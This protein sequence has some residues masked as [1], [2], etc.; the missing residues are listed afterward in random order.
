ML[1]SCWS[2]SPSSEKS[3]EVSA[4]VELNQLSYFDWFVHIVID[5]WFPVNLQLYYRDALTT[6]KCLTGRAP[7]YLTAK[8]TKRSNISKRV[9]R[10]SQKLNIP[11]FRTASG[12]RTFCYHAVSLWND[13][14]PSLKACNSVQNFK[15][16]L[17]SKLLHN[18]LSW[19]DLLASLSPLSYRYC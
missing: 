19:L 8:F 11:L 10:N 4:A 7:V 14:E 18:F 9:T 6:F 16:L 3:Q 17:K 15:H 13:L 2:I 5:S 12:Q 1:P